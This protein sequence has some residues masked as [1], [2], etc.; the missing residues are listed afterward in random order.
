MLSYGKLGE[1]GLIS[2]L[3]YAID[4]KCF[5][6][7]SG[8]NIA[9]RLTVRRTAVHGVTDRKYWKTWFLFA[10][11]L[12]H[13]L[14]FFVY[15][16]QSQTDSDVC[17]RH[18]NLQWYTLCDCVTKKPSVCFSSDGSLRKHEGENIVKQHSRE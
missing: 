11:N 2:P 3:G 14:S 12:A 18:C 10:K 16:L 8:Q 15:K 17:T 4:A 5:S 9:S 13:I 6:C 7:L 1:Y